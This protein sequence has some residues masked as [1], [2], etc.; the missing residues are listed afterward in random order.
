M[1]SINDKVD[2]TDSPTEGKGLVCR[3]PVRRG[4]VVWNGD[5]ADENAFFR[6]SISE[7]ETWPREKQDDFLH[8]AF[9]ISDD[10]FEG[11]FSDRMELDA[12]N[13]FNHSCDPNC[14]FEPG[15]S[16]NLIAR[17]DI[18]PGEEL[19]FDY[20][21]SEAHE[22][23][24]DILEACLCSADKSI[25]RKVV[26]CGDWQLP[27]LQERYRG[28]FMP[29][30]N[31]RIKNMKYGDL[32]MTTLHQHIELFN[33]PIAG[34]GLLCVEA[35]LEGEVVWNGDLAVEDSSF[36]V[37]SAEMLTWP[38]DQ[39]EDFLHYAFQVGEDEFEGCFSDRKNLDA[40]NFMNHSCDPNCWFDNG[41]PHRLIARRNISPGEELT[42]DYAMSESSHRPFEVLETC[43]CSAD[44]PLCRGKVRCDDWTIPE[45]QERYHGHFMPYLNHKI[46]E[47]KREATV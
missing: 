40:G 27:E 1:R 26:R 44:K 13:F 24:F 38:G 4:E 15:N 31:R 25:C 29:Y 8:F 18:Q 39:L 23:P 28:H 2:L 36:K 47:V 30:L 16:H 3:V 41:N 11:C 6:V 21:M 22:W 14:W 5:L 42:Y 46:E 32:T 19:T 34:R 37:S 20:A 7:I 12:G 33:S 10:E 35:I 17:R 9:Q 43:M 45:L